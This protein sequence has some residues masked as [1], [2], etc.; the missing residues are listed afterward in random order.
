M[1]PV[2]TALVAVALGCDAFA[3][4]MGVG[5]RFCRPRQVFRLSFHFGLFQF[6][7]PLLGWLLGQNLVGLARQWGPWIAFALLFLIGVRMSHESLR[8]EAD[9]P[10]GECPDPTR[11][12]S[13]VMLSVAT[14]IDALAVGFSFSLLKTDLLFPAAIIGVVCFVM[15][16]FGMIFGKGLARMFGKKVEILGGLVLIAIGVVL[17]P[18]V[19]RHLRAGNDAAV[20]DS[21]NRSL[22]FAMLLTVPAAMALFVVPTV[23]TLLAA[24]KM[25]EPVAA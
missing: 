1:R 20:K 13:L 17:L 19:S 24:R 7:M 2:E 21:Q 23:Y 22:E 8:S 16:A 4:G 6:L 3:V 10:A 15:T 12:F 18:D 25:P 11:G 5:T 9:E 14:S